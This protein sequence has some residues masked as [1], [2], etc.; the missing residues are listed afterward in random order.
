VIVFFFRSGFLKFEKPSIQLVG[1][2]RFVLLFLFSSVRQSYYSRSS[3]VVI[4]V[5]SGN[6]EKKTD[7]LSFFFSRVSL[8]VLFFSGAM[9]FLW[10]RASRRYLQR[11]LEKRR[12]ER[13]ETEG[14]SGTK[15]CKNKRINFLVNFAEERKKEKERNTWL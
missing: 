9:V 12:E 14:R 10:M 15:Q 4:F 8:I 13:K 3:L 6:C 5:L 1:L 2:C 11:V 7:F